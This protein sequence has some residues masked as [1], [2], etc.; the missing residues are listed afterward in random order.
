MAL[1]TVIVMCP[2]DLS[3][4]TY[5]VDRREQVLRMLKDGGHRGRC[6]PPE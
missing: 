5:P 1:R 4:F 3:T 2:V 6:G